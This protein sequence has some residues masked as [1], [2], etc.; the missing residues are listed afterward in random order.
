MPSVIRP[1]SNARE[2]IV[3]I[4]AEIDAVLMKQRAEPPQPQLSLPM[5]MNGTLNGSAQLL[6]RRSL[7]SVS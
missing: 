7:A 5:P 1:P 2:A 4:I 6:A 3:I